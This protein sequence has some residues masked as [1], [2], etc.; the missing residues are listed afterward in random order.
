MLFYI[1]GRQSSRVWPGTPCPLYVIMGFRNAEGG[2]VISAVY[3]VFST[4]SAHRPQ[5]SPSCL[6]KGVEPA[7]Q[8]SLR[9][10]HHNLERSH[11]TSSSIN[12][13]SSL[14]WLHYFTYFCFHKLTLLK[15]CCF[16]VCCDITLRDF[17]APSLFYLQYGGE[18]MDRD[19]EDFPPDLIDAGTTAEAETD[20][21]LVKVPITIVTGPWE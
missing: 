9:L 14:Q 1:L 2:P 17:T 19:D 13:R 18:N 6:G 11:L 21:R 8:Y 16:T 15:N 20:E 5:T 3:S 7:Y 4:F 12:P 10:N